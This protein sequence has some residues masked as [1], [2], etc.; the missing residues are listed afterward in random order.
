[1]PY[2]KEIDRKRLSTLVADIN[3]TGILSAGEIQYIIA[4]L[5]KKF[6]GKEYRYQDLNDVMGALDGAG[7]EFY[8]R[9]V[10]PYEDKKIKENGDVY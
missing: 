10:A 7:K 2:I 8:R 3:H 5:I 9:K 4:V 1:M 6:L